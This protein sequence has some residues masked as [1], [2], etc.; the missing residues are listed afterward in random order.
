MQENGKISVILNGLEKYMAFSI[1][2]HL[3]FIK[4]MQFMKSSLETL[5]KN[6]KHY[7]NNKF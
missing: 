5:V 7:S 1:N 2:K 4:C 3:V 6:L